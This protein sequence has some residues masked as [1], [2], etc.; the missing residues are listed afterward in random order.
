[1]LQV[2]VTHHQPGFEKPGVVRVRIGT[3]ESTIRERPVAHI[4]VD[5]K[6]AWEEICGTLPQHAKIM[7]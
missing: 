1:L 6:A 3:I 7:E 4:F 5:S 2:R